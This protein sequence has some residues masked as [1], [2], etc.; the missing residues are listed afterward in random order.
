M[1]RRPCLTCG[2]LTN[3]TRCPACQRTLDRAYNDRGYRR[4]R[5]EIRAG[6]HGP[7]IDCA[8]W[9]DLT[10]DHLIPV[11]KGGAGGPIVVRC[12]SCNSRRGAP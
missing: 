12:R 4:L 8:T 7:C 10:C 1:T 9:H 3:A 2:R 6:Q 5:S 11:T